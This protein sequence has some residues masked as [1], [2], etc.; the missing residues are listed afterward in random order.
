MEFAEAKK[1]LNKG[2]DKYT[3]E[4]IKKIMKIISNL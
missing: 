4:E 1:V 2:G 3:D